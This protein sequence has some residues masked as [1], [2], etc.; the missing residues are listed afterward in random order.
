MSRPGRIRKLLAQRLRGLYPETVRDLLRAQLAL[1]RSAASVRTCPVGSFAVESAGSGSSE[2]ASRADAIESQT[3]DWVEPPDARASQI[4]SAIARA[5]RFG[6]FRPSCLVRAIALQKLLDANGLTG[7][8]VHVGVWS[9]SGNFA[10]HAWVEYGDR[11]LGESK[12]R[13]GRFR[14]LGHLSVHADNAPLLHE[15]I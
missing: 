11:V 2:E 4:S 10:A 6:L 5:A 9:D 13:V 14:R 12:S 15:R 3:G 1:L 8:T 7:S